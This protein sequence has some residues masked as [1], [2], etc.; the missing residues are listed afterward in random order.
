MPA[1]ARWTASAA[2]FTAWRDGDRDALD[3]LVRLLSPILW[4]VVRATG[5]D[6]ATAED[7]V[8]NTWL[9]LV[10]N[11]EA[12]SSPLAVSGWLCTTARREAWKVSKRVRREVATDGDVLSWALPAVDG[13]EDGIVLADDQ[14]VLRRCLSRISERCQSLLRML[15]AG[16]RPEYAEVSEALDMPVGSIGP[17]RAR[18]LDKLRGELISEGAF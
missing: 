10:D 7:V 3:E 2:A 17:T 6:R 11:A 13:P 1:S 14:V 16:P 15:A 8:Q 12:I 4:Q 9:T 18:C 5:L